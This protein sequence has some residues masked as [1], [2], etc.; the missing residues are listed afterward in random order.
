M[1]G[2]G[3]GN[4]GG[5]PAAL[6]AAP[7][8]AACRATRGSAASAKRAKNGHRSRA[9]GV[10]IGPSV[11]NRKNGANL[12]SVCSCQISRCR[13]CVPRLRQCRQNTGSRVHRTPLRGGW[14]CPRSLVHACMRDRGCVLL[15]AADFV[16]PRWSWTRVRVQ[17]VPSVSHEVTIPGIVSL[18][19]DQTIMPLSDPS[20]QYRVDARHVTSDRPELA[21]VLP[22]DVPEG[23][24]PKWYGNAILKRV[25]GPGARDIIIPTL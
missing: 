20:L 9:D 3:P 23:P 2:E 6:T 25:R 4:R 5:P 1:T 17:L 8:S 13:C 19:S 22:F 24:E 14:D 18:V 12:N 15:P 7:R 21:T 10:S 16:P 11:I